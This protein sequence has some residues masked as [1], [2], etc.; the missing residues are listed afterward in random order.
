MRVCVLARAH[1][2]AFM[3]GGFDALMNPTTARQLAG[4]FEYI[5]GPYSYRLYSYGLYSYGL[6]SL[7][8]A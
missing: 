7:W 2:R 6:Y 4:P 1:V 8:S 5:Y 3:S